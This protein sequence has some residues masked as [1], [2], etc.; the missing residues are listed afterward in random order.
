MTHFQ[1]TI[2]ASDMLNLSLLF[3]VPPWLRTPRAPRS[4]P[5]PWQSPGRRRTSPGWPR[6]SRPAGGCCS[7]RRPANTQ[8]VNSTFPP[9]FLISLEA[10]LSHHV[11]QGVVHLDRRVGGGGELQAIL[12]EPP[13]VPIVAW[14]SRHS[15]IFIFNFWKKVQRVSDLSDDTV[16]TST[17]KQGQST[18]LHVIF[19]SSIV[20]N[21]DHT[22]YKRVGVLLI[23]EN[24]AFH[25]MFTLYLYA[26]WLSV[27]CIHTAVYA[28]CSAVTVYNKYCTLSFY[29]VQS[30]YT[31]ER[32]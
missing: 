6:R 12:S 24:E 7:G 11:D 21:R 31:R 27:L 4:S 16:T 15:Q 26:V 25:V 17:T 10:V 1:A 5:S 20:R 18:L 19:L 28:L 13:Q 9:T 30:K 22:V 8:S 2:F 3:V 32:I 29:P 23:N 14:K